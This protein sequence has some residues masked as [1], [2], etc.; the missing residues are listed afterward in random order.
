MLAVKVKVEPGH[1]IPAPVAL[2]IVGIISVIINAI[3]VETQVV[4]TA[5]VTINV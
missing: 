4:L 5:S 3:D 1:K 2:V